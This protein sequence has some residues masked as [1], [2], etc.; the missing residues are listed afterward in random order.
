MARPENW[1]Q[2]TLREVREEVDTW[3]EWKRSDEVREVFEG[4]KVLGRHPIY[5]S[6]HTPLE[7]AIEK[8]IYLENRL[9]RQNK[10]LKE[11]LDLT[12]SVQDQ[13]ED[14]KK[15]S[16]AE[17][18]PGDAWRD[19]AEAARRGERG[20]VLYHVAEAAETAEAESLAASL[21]KCRGGG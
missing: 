10:L 14:W 15:R 19:C 6:E 1:L 4:L 18:A 20:D 9:K 2:R 17:R 21:V 3:P 16:E 11:S 13:C 5:S 8:I 7:V 12:D